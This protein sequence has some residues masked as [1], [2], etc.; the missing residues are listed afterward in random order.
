MHRDKQQVHSLQAKSQRV[1]E[2]M[3]HDGDTADYVLHFQ[4]F[5]VQKKLINKVTLTKNKNTF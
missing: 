3:K 2:L 5:C 4:Y 1:E